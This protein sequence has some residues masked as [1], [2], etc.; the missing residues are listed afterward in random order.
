[1]RKPRARASSEILCVTYYTRDAG[2]AGEKG[3]GRAYTRVLNALLSM[4]KFILCDFFVCARVRACV[5]AC[6]RAS[7]AW[8]WC[9]YERTTQHTKKHTA[10]AP[11]TWLLIVGGGGGTRQPFVHI[12]HIALPRRCGGGRGVGGVTSALSCVRTQFYMDFI[13]MTARKR[14]VILIKYLVI[15]YRYISSQWGLMYCANALT[16]V[17]VSACASRERVRVAREW[18][19]RARATK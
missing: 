2:E 8:F 19:A 15:N 17:C 3:R 13:F 7:G 6:V 4:W 1:M 14:D 18:S 10:T 12:T 11:F 16:C 5:R 9:S